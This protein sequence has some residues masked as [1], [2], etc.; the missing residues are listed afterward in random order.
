[1]KPAITVLEQIKL[2]KSQ[3]LI[4]EDEAK[5]EYFLRHNSYHR[6]SVYWQKYKTKSGECENSFIDN[7]TFEQIVAIYELDILLRNILQKGIG[8]FEV[9]LRTKFA[10]Y[11]ALSEPNGQCL[12]LEKN[13]YTNKVLKNENPYDLIKKI[14]KELERSDEKFIDHYKGKNESVPIWV[15]MEVLS[16]GTVSKMYSLWANKEVT[17]K[18]IRG[19][20]L[21]KDYNSSIHIIRSLVILR[22][23]CAHHSRIWNRRLIA[24]VPDK[25]YLKKFGV[26]NERSQWRIISVLMALVDEI[27]RNKQFSCD[28]MKLCKRNQ[29]FYKGLLEYSSN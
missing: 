22:N 13:S 19:L 23:L 18:V 27:N 21:F 15:A 6:L 17:K 20:S 7:T 8:I 10:Y 4:F 12:Y 1:M 26:S 14:N 29:E 16:F 24:Q 2:L 9:S 28:V 3:N 11:M 5:A 25:E